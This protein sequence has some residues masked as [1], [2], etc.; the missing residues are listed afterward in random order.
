MVAGRVVRRIAARL[1]QIDLSGRFYTAE[2]GTPEEKDLSPGDTVYV[3]VTAKSGSRAILEIVD[4]EFPDIQ[5]PSH[6]DLLKLAQ[7]AGWP[8]DEAGVSLVAALVARRMPLRS[9]MA[10]SLYRHLKSLDAPTV[11]DA[12]KFLIDFFQSKA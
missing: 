2:M 12:E 6:Q 11:Q 10:D 8:K 7:A 3:R 4:P 9:D 5:S 1:Y